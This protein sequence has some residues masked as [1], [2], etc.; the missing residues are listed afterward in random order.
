MEELNFMYPGAKVEPTRQYTGLQTTAV[1]R[2]V[3]S[4]SAGLAEAQY[5]V[6][7]RDMQSNKHYKAGNRKRLAKVGFETGRSSPSDQCHCTAF[8]M[9][10]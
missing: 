4:K 7:Q 5:R 10:P 1:R 2:S 3:P 6:R 9:G 8:E